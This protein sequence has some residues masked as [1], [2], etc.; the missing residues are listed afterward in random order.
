MNMHVSKPCYAVCTSKE[1]SPA[2]LPSHYSH[3]GQCVVYQD[4]D[5]T[6]KQ[7]YPAHIT[8]LYADKNCQSTQCEYMQPMEQQ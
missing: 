5:N 8:S 2:V 1:Q 3:V 6:C 7:W 4:Q